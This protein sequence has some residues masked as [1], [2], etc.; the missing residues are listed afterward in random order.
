MSAASLLRR[1]ERAADPTSAG[2]QMFRGDD[3]ESAVT[4][5]LQQ[6]LNTRQGSALTIPDYGIVEVSELL[7]DFVSTANVV[8]RCVK[9]TISKYEPR[10]KNV[11]VRSIEPEEDSMTYAMGFEIT[12]QLVDRGGDRHA[13]RFVMRIDQSSSVRFE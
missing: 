11:Q 3:I 8:Q 10:L 6:M 1:L 9:N 5:H 12:A 2:R 7:H 13:V 4:N